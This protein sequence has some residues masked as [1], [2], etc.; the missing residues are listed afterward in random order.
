MLSPV[1]QPLEPDSLADK[2][3]SL[4]DLP[5]LIDSDLVCASALLLLAY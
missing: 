3:D 1:S 5:D 4:A 2:S